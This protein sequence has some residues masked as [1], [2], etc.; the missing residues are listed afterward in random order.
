MKFRV[1]ISVVTA[2]FISGCSR[3]I[4]G[5]VAAAIGENESGCTYIPVDRLPASTK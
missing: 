2:V 4:D 1:A 3:L 5:K